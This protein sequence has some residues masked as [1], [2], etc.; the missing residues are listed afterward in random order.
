VEDVGVGIL[1]LDVLCQNVCVWYMYGWDD[2]RR[3]M[4]F[5]LAVRSDM[6]SGGGV[7]TL[8][9]DIGNPPLSRM[10]LRDLNQVV[11]FV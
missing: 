2:T 11:I 10:V 1:G 6:V 7:Y 4:G 9:N 8:C 5:S 3:L